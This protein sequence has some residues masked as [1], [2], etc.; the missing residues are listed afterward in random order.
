MYK[1]QML[2]DLVRRDFRVR[3]NLGQGCVLLKL[4]YPLACSLI[5]FY[6]FSNS[7]SEI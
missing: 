1:H 7:A 5:G 3:P 2:G 4:P 6:L